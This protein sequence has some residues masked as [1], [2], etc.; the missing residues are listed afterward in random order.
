[1]SRH[2]MDRHFT[3]DDLELYALNRLAPPKV[4]RVEAHLVVCESCRARL[5]EAEA[6]IALIRAVLGAD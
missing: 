6:L 2:T 1:M 5:G 4:E 3:D